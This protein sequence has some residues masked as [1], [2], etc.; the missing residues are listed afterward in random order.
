MNQEEWLTAY[1]ESAFAGVEL[2]D[3]IDIQAAESMDD[4]GNP[5]EEQL[6]KIAERRDWRRVPHAIMFPRFWAVTFL[7]A[8]GFRFCAPATMTALVQPHDPRE[9]LSSWFFTGL[10]VDRNGRIK[11]VPFKSLFT[12][13]QKAA[14]VRF[15]KYAVHNR[16]RHF[17]ASEAKRRLNEIQT[18]T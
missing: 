5:R 13:Q 4:Y 12:A 6:S 9:C 10:H 3:G 17:D 11:G 1:I 16:H 15:L 8:V 2:G 7:D 18:R 14:I